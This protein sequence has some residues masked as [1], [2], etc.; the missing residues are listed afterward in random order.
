MKITIIHILDDKGK[1]CKGGSKSSSKT[2]E[3]LKN[4]E[5]ERLSRK[6]TV[7]KNLDHRSNSLVNFKQKTIDVKYKVGDKND[8]KTRSLVSKPKSSDQDNYVVPVKKC[9][10]NFKT[11][12]KNNKSNSLI[13]AKLSVEVKRRTSSMD[14]S[15][16]VCERK[17]TIRLLQFNI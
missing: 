4:V 3:D 8:R 17:D 15:R 16:T 1:W 14:N 12:S 10:K 13:E 2:S 9:D 7:S 11:V 6:K 5:E